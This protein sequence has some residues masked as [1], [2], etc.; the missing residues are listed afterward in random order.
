MSNIEALLQ[1]LQIQ[2]KHLNPQTAL[3]P[4]IEDLDSLLNISKLTKMEQPTVI[5]YI[6]KN[7]NFLM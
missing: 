6:N 4:L 5:T 3:K 7:D 2:S 1:K